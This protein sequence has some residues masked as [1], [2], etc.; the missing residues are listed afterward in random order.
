MDQHMSKKVS[1]IIPVYNVELYIRECLESVVNQQY[2]NLEILLI[3]DGSDDSSGQICDEYALMDS[4]VR[5]V[6]KKNGGVSS[7]RNCG[8]EIASGDYVYFADADDFLFRDTIV[9]LCSL[10][11]DHDIAMCMMQKFD[12]GLDVIQKESKYKTTMEIDAIVSDIL[13]GSNS[14]GFLWNKLFKAEIIK[15]KK[16]FF[17][18]KVHHYE[19]Q[20][21]ILE[22]LDRESRA[23]FSDSVIYAY[24]NTPGS[25]LNSGINNKS[26]TMIYARELIYNRSKELT[27]NQQIISSEYEKLIGSLIHIYH[28]TMTGLLEKKWKNEIRTI[29]KKY[30]GEYRLNSMS[31]KKKLGYAL[32]K[33]GV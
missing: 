28:G 9:T 11:M 8:L 17:N 12:N 24:R 30:R 29:E 4:R 14:S 32:L 26:A 21:F 19:D 27:I 10:I 5:V 23:A 22:Y 25:A 6:H 15:E 13:T 31:L 2:D 3:D 20:L 16:L 7:A 1:V 33:L 18:T